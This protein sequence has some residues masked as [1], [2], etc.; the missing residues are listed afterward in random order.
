[1]IQVMVRAPSRSCLYK[2]RTPSRK[3]VIKTLTRKSFNASA[4][5]MVQSPRMLNS[6]TVKLALKIRKEMKDLSCDAY[7]SVLRDSVEAVKCFHWET[8][9]LEK[10][11]H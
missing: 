9:H 10:F 8:V 2:V 7:D 6:I 3:R 5:T 1:M 4:S 11:L